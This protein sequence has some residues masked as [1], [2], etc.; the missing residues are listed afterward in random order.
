MATAAPEIPVLARDQAFESLYRRH[1]KDVYHYALAL[2]RN[3]D[4]AEDV[5]QTTFLNAYRAYQRGLEI[6]KPHN[7]LIKIAHNVAR[8]RY[9]RA[10][11]RVKEVPLED[12]VAELAAP[13]LEQPDVAGVL[14]A[15][16]R[17]PFNQRAA[18]V[19]RELE[20]RTYAEIADTIGVSVSA[21]ET[22][23][24]RARRSLRL[25]A[26][27]LR[28]L[29]AAPLPT[30][31]TQFFDGG[32]LV[33]GSGTVAG[34]G[35]LVKAAVALIAAALGTAVSGDHRGPATAAAQPGAGFA[36]ARSSH[37]GENGRRAGQLLRY[38]VRSRQSATRKNAVAKPAASGGERGV[39]AP[40]GATAQAAAGQPASAS[41][42]APV[43]GTAAPVSE[44]TTTVSDPTSSVQQVVAAPASAL[45]VPPPSLPP[46]PVQV[47]PLPLPLPPPPL[48]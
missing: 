4:D 3:P 15:L 19:M 43:A 16:G 40:D 2:L 46:A 26:S 10:G 24:F 48:P 32:G 42:N 30:S 14:R 29:A 37:A 35:F 11:R 27:A 12:H 34:T 20:G 9:A 47:P 1:V 39:T 6:E 41:S 31:L 13:E 25:R 45:P 18:L 36:V 38:G 7:W 44:V 5:T 21:V 17:L 23:I 33:A 8:T 22:L 28:S